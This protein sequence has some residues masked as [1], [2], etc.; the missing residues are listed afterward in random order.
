M[1]NSQRWLVL[2]KF[3]FGHERAVDPCAVRQFFLRNSQL[4][5]SSFYF[6]RKRSHELW[7]LGRAHARTVLIQNCLCTCIY[8]TKR[9]VCQT[10]SA[11]AKPLLSCRGPNP[12]NDAGARIAISFLF[13]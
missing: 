10:K 7:I 8:G 9:A 12:I 6:G 4:S 13:C 5:P 11:D 2:R 3:D 1:Q